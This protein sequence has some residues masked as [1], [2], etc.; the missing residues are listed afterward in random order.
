MS[1]LTLCLPA[2]LPHPLNWGHG[3]DLGG[4][5]ALICAEARL[6]SPES[7]FLILPTLGL[8]EV[9]ARDKPRQVQ[10]DSMGKGEEEQEHGGETQ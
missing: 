4:G 10:G 8:S 1:G 5:T 9:H 3:S 6:R 2:Q 7:P